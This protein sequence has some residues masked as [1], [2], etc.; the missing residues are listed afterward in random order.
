VYYYIYRYLANIDGV[1]PH[2]CIGFMFARIDG[3]DDIQAPFPPTSTLHSTPS[4][5]APYQLMM[6]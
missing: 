1:S 6:S 2:S 5:P 4:N 3:C